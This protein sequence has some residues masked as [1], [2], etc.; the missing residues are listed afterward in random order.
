MRGHILDKSIIQLG[1]VRAYDELQSMHTVITH[2]AER[3]GINRYFL[4]ST[5]GSYL[6]VPIVTA[7][8]NVLAALAHLQEGE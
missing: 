7:Q 2:E 3:Q 6:L 1:L 8:A 5:D 4:R